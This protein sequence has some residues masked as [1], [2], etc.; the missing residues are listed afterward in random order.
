MEKLKVRNIFDILYI[1]IPLRLRRRRIQAAK[2]IEK[3]P[4]GAPIARAKPQS[5]KQWRSQ[6]LIV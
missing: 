3:A 6:E 2:A 5:A 4:F 1:Y